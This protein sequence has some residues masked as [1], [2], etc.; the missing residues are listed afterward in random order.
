VAV[1][2]ESVAATGE[3]ESARFTGVVGDWI[4]PVATATPVAAAASPVRLTDVR[5]AVRAG[6]RFAPA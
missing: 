5:S 2:E 1:S 3:S 6:R 4:T